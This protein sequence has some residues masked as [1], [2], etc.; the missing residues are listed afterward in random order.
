MRNSEQTK[1]AVSEVF[2]DLIEHPEKLEQVQHLKA[3][4]AVFTKNKC[5]QLLKRHQNER[6]HLTEY[7][8]YEQNNSL[9]I[10]IQ[11][12]FYVQKEH[13]FNEK[14]LLSDL[15]KALDD[16]KVNHRNCIVL[17]YLQR[18]S[19]K[20]IMS[21]TNY[22]FRQVDNYLYYGKRKLEKILNTY[23]WTSEEYKKLF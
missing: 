20:E 23:G 6:N 19:Y 13:L 1:D 5:L 4:L 3:W 2:T 15:Q 16:L 11:F 12:N 8:D 17:H 9:S 22:S 7:F 14:R 18:K 10:N 21:V